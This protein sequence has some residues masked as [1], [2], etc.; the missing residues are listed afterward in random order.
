MTAF[1]LG[2][3]GR[4]QIAFVLAASNIIGALGFS[5]LHVGVLKEVSEGNELAPRVGLSMAARISFG[6][7][8]ASVVW[9]GFLLATDHA[10]TAALVLVTGMGAA[11]V[12][13]NLFILRACQALGDDEG[14]KRGWLI[15]GLMMVFPGI[16]ILL[17]FPTVTPFLVVWLS[18][19]FAS[20][21]YVFRRRTWFAPEYHGAQRRRLLSHSLRAHAGTVGTQVLNRLP[22]VALGVTAPPA[23]VGVYSVAAPISELT[24]LISEAFSLLAFRK[25]VADRQQKRDRDRTLHALHVWM[26]TVSAAV[27]A[28]GVV[29]L[30]PYILPTFPEVPLLV[31]ILLPGVL[32]QGHARVAMS[33]VTGRGGVNASSRIGII[34]GVLSL[35]FFPVAAAWGAIGV[36]TAASVLFGLQGIGV[37]LV[38]RQLARREWGS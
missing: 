23:T 12:V 21:L 37:L 10:D 32:V 38:D 4:G 31:L 36:A 13:L 14:F 20:A 33:R 3:E 2:P 27:I 9:S 1:L 5:S 19:L 29:T 28:V 35:T 25:A 24:W 22:V 18:S 11:L 15:Q 34:S 7:F 6:I 17:V 16:P 8:I 26:T 30:F